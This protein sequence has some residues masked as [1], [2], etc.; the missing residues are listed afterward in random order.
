MGTTISKYLTEWR[1]TTAAS[2][3]ERSDLPLP[4]V[5][6]SAGYGSEAAFSRAFSRHHGLPPGAFR[7][8]ARGVGTDSVALPPLFHAALAERER[9]VQ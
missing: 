9:R 3:L 1:M 6:A 2:L 7:R 4:D 5:A 8:S